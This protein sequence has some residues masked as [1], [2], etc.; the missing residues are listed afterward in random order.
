MFQRSIIR[1]KVAASYTTV[2]WA[3][4]VFLNRL[5]IWA[6]SIFR[7][8]SARVAF[9]HFHRLVELVRQLYY[10]LLLVGHKLVLLLHHI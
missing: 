10:L 5:Y 4:D 1:L 6:H 3:H 7:L 9:C 8:S 2:L